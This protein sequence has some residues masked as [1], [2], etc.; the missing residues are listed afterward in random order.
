VKTDERDLLAN[1]AAGG[2]L[3][4]RRLLFVI[5]DFDFFI[6]HRLPVALAARN[7]GMD[8]HIAA[9]DGSAASYLRGK[10]MAVHLIPITR[11]GVHPWREARALFKLY[12]LCR[13][14][15]PDIV[16]SVTIKGVIYGGIAARLARV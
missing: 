8:V 10:G 4:N 16:H 3:K 7:A 11:S 5:N 1:R 13:T 12:Q 15:Q 14:L 6:S 2:S 9:A